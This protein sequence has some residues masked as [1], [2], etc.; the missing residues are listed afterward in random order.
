[1]AWRMKRPLL[2]WYLAAGVALV[3]AIA[4]TVSHLGPFPPRVVVMTTGSAGSA[5]DAFGQSYREILARSGVELR[6]MPSA[7]GVENLNR[8]NDPRSGVTVGFVQGGLTSEKKSPKLMSL[9]TLFYE[10]I[11]LFYRGPCPGMRLDDLRGRKVSIGPE[12][13]GTRAV[14]L[15]F[16]ALNGL[17]QSIVQQLPMTAVEASD[18]LLRG[19]IDGA[20]IVTSWDSASVRRLLADPDVNLCGF[21]RADAYVALYPFLTKLVLPTGVGNMAANRPPKDT[22]LLAPKASLVVR[23]DL[24]PA[25]QYLLLDAAS[26]IHSGP[27]IFQKSGQ[28]PAAERVDLPLS[29]D[30][31][32]FYKSGRPFLQRYLPFWLAVLTGHLLVLLI[33]VVGIAYPLLRT[34]PAA[35]AWSMRRR[36]FRLYGELK[37]I[38]IELERGPAGHDLEALRGRL[39]RLEER[40]NHFRTPIAFTHMLYTLRDHIGLVRERLKNRNG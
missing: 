21:P 30:A 12:G 1:L 32:Q 3:A 14:A 20:V 38:E 39:D 13:S 18:S 40:A 22:N 5:Y 31:Q 24:H 7:G 9:G 23:E 28:F 29:E 25:L 26:Q 37:L 27:G 36:I 2:W 11:W 15:Q 34:A 8:L 19:E 4:A 35:Y 10:P 17:D 33:P 16:L 6:L